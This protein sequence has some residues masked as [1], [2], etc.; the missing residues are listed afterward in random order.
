MQSARLFFPLTHPELKIT[1]YQNSG[2]PESYSHSVLR[3]LNHQ[4][5]SQ[6]DL[7][8]Q[9]EYPSFFRGL[10]GGESLFI[11]K[12]NKIA[13]HV[14][15]MRRRFQHPG[16]KMELGLI[17]SVATHKD[18]RGEGLAS[19]LL[20]EAVIRLKKQGCTLALL[21]SDQPDFY[22][23]LG[24]HRAGNELD[25]RISLVKAEAAQPCC[26]ILNKEKDVESVW[27]LYQK[28]N[29]KLERS[30]AEM[31]ALINIPRTQ[32]YVTGSEGKTDSYIAIH[33]GADFTNYIHEWGGSLEAV[34]DNIQDCQNRYFP[35]TP[36]TLIAPF[37][38]ENETFSE[39]SDQSWKGSLG[40]VKLLDRN[41]LVS[42]FKSFSEKAG[43][44]VSESDYL[45][46]NDEELLLAVLGRDGVGTRMF[47]PLFLWGFDSI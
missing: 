24:F 4:L 38:K 6:S 8:L 3:F 10:P 42:C 28:R 30:L 22:L 47:L 11:E 21:W 12:E 19:L 40:L 44:N 29:S 5:R 37:E 43:M 14:G 25:F 20:Q 13:S 34:K 1:S 18:H 31:T 46:L 2:S 36:L 26:R 16:F 7:I 17:G 9:D 33:K 35:Q 45:N 27:K 41:H 15:I 32:V 23:P 39:I